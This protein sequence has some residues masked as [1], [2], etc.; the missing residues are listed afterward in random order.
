MLR[1]SSCGIIVYRIYSLHVKLI[2][3]IFVGTDIIDHVVSAQTGSNGKPV[4]KKSI[5]VFQHEIAVE[6][7]LKRLLLTIEAFRVGIIILRLALCAELVADICSSL[8]RKRNLVFP[9]VDVKAHVPQHP[10]LIHAV[11]ELIKHAIWVVILRVADEESI[12]LES[13]RV[14]MPAE[15]FLGIFFHADIGPVPHKLVHRR[16]AGICGRRHI[17]GICP[18]IVDLGVEFYRLGHRHVHGKRIALLLVTGVRKNP[19]VPRI[20]ERG[21][22]GCALAVSALHCN[23]IIPRVAGSEDTCVPVILVCPRRR[24][25]FPGL[26]VVPF[27]L[28]SELACIVCLTE[29]ISAVVNLQPFRIKLSPPE[30]IRFLSHVDSGAI[31]S[32]EFRPVARHIGS[33]CPAVCHTYAFC[34]CSTL[35]RYDNGPVAG[36]GAVQG[37]RRST[38]KYGNRFYVIRIEV[39]C[40]VTEIHRTV[41][42]GICA[43]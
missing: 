21:P 4:T 17:V 11:C 22:H 34:R 41:I 26:P 3:G 31:D 23:S 37:S 7:H 32:V 9:Q 42:I 30:V 38:F 36:T 35:G 12:V 8:K 24:H 40:P 27:I 16:I 10:V 29:S 15:I 19:L 5:R 1:Q 13:L 18:V 14:V 20:L 33:E 39:G 43:S 25:D 28:V 2:Y 6:L